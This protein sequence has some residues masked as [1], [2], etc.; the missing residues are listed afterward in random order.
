[1]RSRS[2]P[3]FG[4]SLA[5]L[6]PSAAHAVQASMCSPSEPTCERAMISVSKLEKAPYDFDFDTGWVPANSPVQVRL[7][8]KLHSRVQVDMEGTLDATWPEPLTLTP[9]GTATKGR[10]TVDEG[11][12]IEAQGRFQVSVGGNNYAWSGKIPGIPSVNLLAQ[13][14]KAFDPWTWRG[15]GPPATASAETP[16]QRVAQI[17]LTDQLIPIPGISGGFELDGAVTFTATYSTLR[18][19][20]DE[21]TG[22]QAV[23]F[24]HPST[25]ALLAGAPSFDTNLLIHGELTRQTTLQFIPGFYFTILGKTFTL[26]IANIPLALPAS[27]PE[28]WDFDPVGVHVPLPKIGDVRDVDLGNVPLDTSTPAVL[29]IKSLGEERLVLANAAMSPIG[30]VD[31]NVASVDPQKTA[32]VRV[33]VTPTA[34]GAFDVPVLLRSNDPLRPVTEVHVRGTAGEGAGPGATPPTAAEQ[35]AGC[36]CVVAGH[37][38]GALGAWAALG[39]A[40]MVALRRRRR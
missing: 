32:T 31:T 15:Q 34:K 28:P 14:S 2:A 39:L 29:E 16:V 17:P 33:V 20:F 1:M 40:A 18:I 21:P 9:K 5:L 37:E 7:L 26:P 27:K 3:V 23:D 24:L 19:G 38:G 6:V 30:F 4:A 35:P 13:S 22:P 8:A 36:G 11:L 10:I 25:R 12:E